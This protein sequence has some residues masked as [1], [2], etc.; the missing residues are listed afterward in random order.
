MLSV[1]ARIAPEAYERGFEVGF[2][3]GYEIG[4]L[5]GARE[6]LFSL[7]WCKYGILSQKNA[8]RIKQ[9]DDA[10]ALNGLCC[11]LLNISSIDEFMAVVDKVLES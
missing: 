11:N 7:F 4:R 9:I 6:I 10:D 8:K 1:A 5:K 2:M 3:I